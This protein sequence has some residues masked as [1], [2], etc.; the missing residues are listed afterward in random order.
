MTPTYSSPAPA[1]EP[2]LQVKGLTTRFHTGHGTVH[3]VEDVSFE[4]RRGET[5]GL[6]GE[7]GSGKSVT[8]MSLLNLVRKPGRI[9]AGQILFRGR[10]ILALSNQALRG[11]RGNGLSMVFQ[12]PMSSL[13]PIMRIG[14]QITEAIHGKGRTRAAA[15]RERA[16]QLMQLVGI[17]DS[18]LR[19]ADYPHRFS[20][21]MRQR[22]MI[23]MA[24]ANEPDVIIA[25]EPTTAL[26][27]TVQAQILDVLADINRERGT[28]IILI[29]HNLGVVARSCDRVAVMYAGRIVEQ[30]RTTELFA[31]P[32]HPY[33]QALLAA[34]PRLLASRA[35]AL[36]PIEGQPPSLTDAI[37]GCA[38]APRCHF[39]HGA[40][41]QQ[42]P[43]TLLGERSF[44]CW[45]TAAGE[46]LPPL[47]RRTGQTL[48][49]ADVHRRT[50][51]S[52]TGPGSGSAP[53]LLEVRDLQV[54][55]AVPSSS[56]NPFAPGRQLHAVDGV[57]FTLG[58]AEAVGLVGESGCGKSSLGKALVGINPV[59]TGQVVFDGQDVT[60]LRGEQRQWVRRQLQMVFQ[61][62]MSA[63]NPRMTIGDALSE[64]LIVHAL[65]KDAAHVR[66]RVDELLHLVGLD[67][68]SATRYPH[69]FS[70]G[71]RQRVVIA[72]GLAVGPKLLVCDEAV[73]ALDVSLQAQVINLLQ[74]LRA[75]LGLSML[76]IG[77]DLASVRYASDRIMVMY[78]GQI[79]EEGPAEL[80][81]LQ[82]QHP[83]TV[84]LLSAVPEPDPVTEAT[85]QRI[86][87]TGDLPSPLDPPSGCRFRTRCPIGPTQRE[88]RERCIT[89]PPTLRPVGNA[90]GKAACHFAGELALPSAG[91]RGIPIFQ[92]P[93][94]IP[95]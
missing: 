85:R 13:N 56:L 34:T 32:R 41:Q 62:P 76:F 75:R 72:R 55:F 36:M 35:H 95:T 59:A 22:V 17:P 58:H 69:E 57:S 53:Q 74:D 79:V 93:E 26:D 80:L 2:V 78:L 92:P 31:D 61:D 89:E 83:Y 33:T 66:T 47:S 84:S 54:R 48:P 11:I 88:G 15:A 63:L 49:P 73:A 87:L 81:T 8:A 29:T 50:A 5:L 64:P 44:A 19:L 7:S 27:V 37:T 9:E 94:L 25:D 43:T 3:A 82:P 12:D 52:H 67:P 30:A 71:Q 23:A 38:F 1:P 70:G 24:L 77:H 68:S 40:C 91:S 28:A 45:R 42:P 46:P 86:V 21:G 65:C 20:G 16:V 6:V 39:V 4:V 51:S 18:T 10:D 60:H 90:G 14:D